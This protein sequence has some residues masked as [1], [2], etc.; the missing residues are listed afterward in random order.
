MLNYKIITYAFIISLVSISSAFA[1]ENNEF[2]LKMKKIEKSGDKKLVSGYEYVK[3]FID[4]VGG[5]IAIQSKRNK[6]LRKI[7]LKRN[8]LKGQTIETLL[9]D[10]CLVFQGFNYRISDNIVNIYQDQTVVLKG[11]DLGEYGYSAGSVF[12]SRIFPLVYFNNLNFIASSYDYITT[13]PEL[14]GGNF[15]FDWFIADYISISLGISRF[16]YKGIYSRNSN[17]I[18]YHNN[19]FSFEVGLNGYFNLFNIHPYIGAAIAYGT[20][21]FTFQTS[22]ID[23]LIRLGVMFRVYKSIYLKFE[24]DDYFPNFKRKILSSGLSFQL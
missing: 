2:P 8:Y 12:L 16:G 17:I 3:S 13:T 5:V 4:Q 9:K 18:S 21:F 10:F 7:K 19:F 24:F 1:N 6:D 11:D 22:K 23:I 14:K 20:D 15:N